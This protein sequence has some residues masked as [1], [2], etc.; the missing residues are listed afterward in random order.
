MA[1]VD[2]DQAVTTPAGARAREAPAGQRCHRTSAQRSAAG[3]ADHA[4]FRSRLRSL[5]R[6]IEILR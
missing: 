5:C 4:R 6:W 1:N 2:L 3:R